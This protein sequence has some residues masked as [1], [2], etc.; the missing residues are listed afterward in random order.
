MK[1]EGK[2]RFTLQFGAESEEQIRVGELLENL[3]NRKSAVIVSALSDYLNSHPELQ[4]GH[5]KIEV[6][7]AS[8]FNHERMEQLIRAVVE[9]KLSELHIT[10]KLADASTSGTS[11]A[12]EEDI[13]QMLDNLDMFN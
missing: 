10:G 2:Y 11:E 9:E 4:S 5:S 13:A 12:L 7:V 3:G 8:T 6:K 1:K